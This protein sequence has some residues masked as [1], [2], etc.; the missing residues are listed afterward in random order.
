MAASHT[1]PSPPRPQ[2]EAPL[3]EVPLPEVPLQGALL[4]VA[5]LPP[6]A[7][8]APLL[9]ALPLA[10]PLPAALLPEPRQAVALPV[11]GAAL[12][13]AAPPQEALLAEAGVLPAEAVALLLG[14]H[15]LGS[16]E[17]PPLA[18]CR[19]ERLSPALPGEAR[20]EALPAALLAASLPEALL[21]RAVPEGNAVSKFGN[22][23]VKVVKGVD[24]KT[25][26]GMFGKADPYAKLKIG[27]QEHQTKPHVQGGKNPVWNQEFE[28]QIST[29]K[30]MEVDIFDKEQVG[31]DKFMGRAK[32][33]IMDWIAMG[34]FQGDIPILDKADKEIGK[35]NVNV[36]FD[37]PG[38]N[39]M[40]AAKGQIAQMNKTGPA[41]SDATAM[42][43]AA[44]A[45]VEPP[46]DPSGKFTDEEI[47]DAFQAFDLDKNNFVGAA[48]IRH[49]LINIG[50][51]VTDEEVDEMIRMVDTDGDG[52]VGFEEFFGMV[53][54]GRKPPPGLGGG[55]KLGAQTDGTSIPPPTGQSVVQARNAKKQGL[56]EFSR[57]NNIKPESVKKAYKRFQA[58]DKDKSGMIDYTEFCEVL[59]IDPSPQCEKVFQMYDYDKSGQIDVREFM[60]GLANF[61]GAGKDD[62]LKFAFM[63]FDE[64][65]NGVITKGE[66]TKIL[67]A[68]HMASSEAEV[69]RKADTIMAQ[70]DKDGDGVVT[71][72][73]FVIV[74]KKF[75]NILFPAHAQKQ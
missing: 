71:F 63:I 75:P 53:T 68:N 59:Q 62:K 13:L 49:V 12:P 33:G 41:G 67:K 25:G 69:A 23:I 10:A 57:D 46:R 36:K 34:N 42:V 6:A 54:G 18:A 35:I 11:G 15:L 61:T 9:A 37:R 16:P 5:H 39:A 8:G 70:A 17:V 40:D 65:G 27:S 22:L 2:H 60:I 56:D 19:L 14:G 45:Q 50:E 48:E 29:E 7:V 74:S 4:L 21:L 58:T 47:W 64:E 31:S 28:F 26:Q 66:L 20:P 38:A 72:E 30:E 44:P 32:V 3:P 52:Q 24:I 43:P 55:G 73:E 51:T 1:P